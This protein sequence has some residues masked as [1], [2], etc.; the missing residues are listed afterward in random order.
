MPHI[1]FLGLLMNDLKNPLFNNLNSDLLFLG[2]SLKPYLHKAETLIHRKSIRFPRLPRN[3]MPVLM[4]IA[5]SFLRH[6]FQL[7][8]LLITPL[9][10][11]S[12]IESYKI[13][14]S[15]MTSTNKR[16]IVSFKIINNKLNFETGNISLLCHGNPITPRYL[17]ILKSV[18]A[19]FLK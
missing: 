16:Q 10:R 3:I 17:R 5:K 2:R 9:F 18:K 6:H 4:Q 13:N 19:A 14:M 7:K 8:I 15:T 11:F 12:S 1:V